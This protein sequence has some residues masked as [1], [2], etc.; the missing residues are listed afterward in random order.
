MKV[1]HLNQSDIKG[2][3]AIA[4]YRLHK[5]LLS[6]N[7]DSEFWVDKKF[8]N[9]PT[10]KLKLN[11][12]ERSIR[13]IVSWSSKKLIKVIGIE[14][15]SYFNFGIFGSPWIR[16]LN[17]SDADIIHLHWLG[18]EI[19]SIKQINKIKKPCIV[20]LH[21]EWLLGDGF[22]LNLYELS[23]KKNNRIVN[24]FMNY[25]CSYRSRYHNKRLGLVAPSSFMARLVDDHPVFKKNKLRT[26]GHPILATDWNPI[27]KIE[28][29][30]KIGVPQNSF[31][32]LFSCFGGL[33]DVNKGFDDF[34]GA[35]QQFVHLNPNVD[36]C[37]IIIG[38]FTELQI[39]NIGA[40]SVLL[41]PINTKI[42]LIEAY[43]ASDV[44]IIPSKYESFGLVAQEVCMLGI[45]IVAY[46]GTGL[47][48]FVMHKANGYLAKRFDYKDLAVG[49]N[50]WNRKTSDSLFNS[51]K[52]ILN[53]YTPDKVADAHISFYKEVLSL[54]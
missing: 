24:I 48:D 31:S 36:L 10:V 42:D 27:T 41:G 8:S 50:F 19:L 18:N 38:N 23:P 46:E 12:I 44:V 15:P 16:Y 13:K 35:V 17:N 7:I 28:A 2:G 4:A 14:S 1:L 49:L 3:A 11:F 22:H 20:T 9:D 29:K 33:E 32:I 25:A 53:A 26:I 5:S 34:C 21:D 47:T 52:A 37:L 40:P 45:P 30:K 43:C 51:N 39:K 54:S 6:Q